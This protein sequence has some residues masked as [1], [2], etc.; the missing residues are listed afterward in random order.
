[1]WNLFSRIATAQQR[2]ETLD[3]F[4]LKENLFKVGDS[5]KRIREEEALCGKGKFPKHSVYSSKNVLDER[6]SS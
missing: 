3:W 6:E 1:M 4:H 5:L 2:H